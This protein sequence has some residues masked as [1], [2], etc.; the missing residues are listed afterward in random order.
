[1]QS[2]VLLSYYSNYLIFEEQAE[3]FYF[4]E[5]FLT[6]KFELLFYYYKIFHIT[7]S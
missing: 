6:L 2:I 5:C 7:T 4:N 1:L 3:A